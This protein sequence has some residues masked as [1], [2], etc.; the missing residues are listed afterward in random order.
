MSFITGYTRPTKT[1][2]LLQQVVTKTQQVHPAPVS[3]SPKDITKKERETTHLG[4]DSPVT[5]LHTI[6][7]EQP[8][9]L[10][11]SPPIFERH[12]QVH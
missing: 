12:V 9:P 11:H 8:M 7:E 10:E 2:A 5:R 1:V 4:H 6:I 3:T